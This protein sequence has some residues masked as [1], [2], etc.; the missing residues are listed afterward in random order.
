[1]IASVD[2]GQDHAG[3]NIV[4]F[5]AATWL[6]VTAVGDGERHSIQY[7]VVRKL[8]QGAV[9]FVG[10]DI[11]SVNTGKAGLL[12]AVC[13]G[14]LAQARLGVEPRTSASGGSSAGRTKIPCSW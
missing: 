1:M 10:S 13:N 2:G 5:S 4:S 11:A 6:P 7:L 9:H 12:Y 8:D 3:K 14:A